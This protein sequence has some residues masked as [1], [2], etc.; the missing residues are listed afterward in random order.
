[1]CVTVL[2]NVNITRLIALLQDICSKGV[3][4]VDFTTTVLEKVQRE[5][6]IKMAPSVM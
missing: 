6:W 4:Q 2:S 1:M 3:E 5:V